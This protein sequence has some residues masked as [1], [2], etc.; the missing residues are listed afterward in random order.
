MP[1]IGKLL[2]ALYK[3]LPKIIF[4][5]L[6]TLSTNSLSPRINPHLTQAN[7]NCRLPWKQKRGTG[8]YFGSCSPCWRY[9]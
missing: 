5:P 8:P 7:W 3:E 1:N 6:T 2:N 4:H 9:D